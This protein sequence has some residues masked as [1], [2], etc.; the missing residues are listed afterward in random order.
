MKITITARHFKAPEKLKLYIENE[1][2]QLEKF[3]NNIID[4]DV[5][6]DYIKPNHSMQYAEIH[7]KVYGNVLKVSATTDD[8]YKSVDKAV[9][10]AEK[11]LQKYKGRQ[12]TFT[13]DKM[14]EHVL[15]DSYY[16]EE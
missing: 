4:C 5:I 13:H 3:F 9:R 10:K 15:E 7:V 12:R 16:E 1:I 2:N 11:K 8:I 14:V 6:L